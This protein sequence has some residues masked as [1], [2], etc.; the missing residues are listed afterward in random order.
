MSMKDDGWK[1]VYAIDGIIFR[2]KFAPFRVEVS[3]M[4][5]LRNVTV[6]GITTS[7]E[8]I[9]ISAYF[10][11]LAGRGTSIHPLALLTPEQIQEFKGMCETELGNKPVMYADGSYVS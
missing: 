9:E 10:G 5:R 11:G 2:K 8:C 3:G 4:V 1:R 6:S 7:G